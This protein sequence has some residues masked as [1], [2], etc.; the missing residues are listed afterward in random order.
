M[1]TVNLPIILSADEAI[2]A[3]RSVFGDTDIRWDVINAN[4]AQLLQD[5]VGMSTSSTNKVVVKISSR[6]VTAYYQNGHGEIIQRS[7]PLGSVGAACADLK[8]L[9]MGDNDPFTN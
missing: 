8:R 5:L 7:R 2:A 6:S 3:A 1:E 9:I 4:S